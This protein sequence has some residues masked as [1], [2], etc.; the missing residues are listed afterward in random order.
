MEKLL[1][2]LLLAPSLVLAQSSGTIMLPVLCAETEEVYKGLQNKYGEKPI[3][4]AIE[5]DTNTNMIVSIWLN[6][7]EKTMTVLKTSKS[8]GITCVL[9]VG[10]NSVLIPE[11][12]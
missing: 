4:Y 2:A 5:P 11:Y 8:Q 7:K 9:V 3:L 6:E 1:A 12:Q 10:D